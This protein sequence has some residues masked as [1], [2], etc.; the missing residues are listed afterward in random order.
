MPHDLLSRALHRRSLALVSLAEQADRRGD[1]GGAR[2]RYEEAARLEEEEALA[3]PDRDPVVIT[4]LAMASLTLW[5][6]AERWAEVERASAAFLARPGLLTPDGRA[7]VES[8]V[9]AARIGA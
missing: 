8:I 1:R 6:R 7:S 9:A 3:L 2:A 4:L 5:I